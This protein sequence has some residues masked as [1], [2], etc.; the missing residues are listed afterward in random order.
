MLK[1]LHARIK[2]WNIHLPQCASLQSHSDE[3]VT[4]EHSENI[5]FFFTWGRVVCLFLFFVF[6]TFTPG[7]PFITFHLNNSTKIMTETFDPLFFL[8]KNFVWHEIIVVLFK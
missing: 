8:P 3:T 6:L 2:L 5:F 1:C 4:Q 7:A